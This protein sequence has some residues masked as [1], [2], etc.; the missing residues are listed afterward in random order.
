M[1]R[2]KVMDHVC[3]RRFVCPVC[4]RFIGV[5]S[6]DGRIRI[7]ITPFD[8]PDNVKDRHTIIGGL[9]ITGTCEC[10]ASFEL[11]KF[12]DCTGEGI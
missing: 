6:S 10:G 9:P 2:R 8:D 5:V 4:G 3:K 12:Y 11:Q 7:T 1:S